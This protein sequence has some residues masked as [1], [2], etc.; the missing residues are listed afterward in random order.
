[1][2]FRSK[3]REL[4]HNV[5]LILIIVLF[6]GLSESLG[7]GSA[8]SA[9]LYKVT[10]KSN[11][12]VGY[13]ESAMG[14]TKLLTAL[15]VGDV[16]DRYGRAPVG[17][18]GSLAYTLATIMTAYCLVANAYSRNGSDDDGKGDSDSS[19]SNG[20]VSTT[21]FALWAIALCLWGF[22]RGV[23]D[24]PVLALFADSVP[25]GDRALFYFYLFVVFWAGALA[26]PVVAVLIFQMQHDEWTYR[27][28][29]VVLFVALA[30]KMVNAVLLCFLRDNA[31]LGAEAEHVTV[32]PSED[33]ME[34]PQQ[35]GDSV[36]GGGGYE[37]LCDEDGLNRSNDDI[38][39][40][41]DGSRD[42]K[43]WDDHTLDALLLDGQSDDGNS[44]RERESATK[45][46]TGNS[47]ETILH[48]RKWGKT[49][50]Q[51][52]RG[53][54]IPHIVFTASLVAQLGA[55]MTVKFFPLYFM[56]D[57][58]ATPATVQA[59]Y[60]GVP[61]AML[62]GGA[63]NGRL[64][65]P[66]GFGRVQTIVLFKGIGVLSLFILVWL[67]SQFQS[68]PLYALVPAFLAQT[69]FT[70]STYPLEESILMDFVPKNRR[71]RWKSLEAV[72]QFGWAGSAILGGYLIDRHD[73]AFT[74]I[75]TAVIQASAVLVWIVLLAVVPREERRAPGFKKSGN[76]EVASN[77]S[78]VDS[79][80]EDAT[81]DG[82]VRG[83]SMSDNVFTP[84][85]KA[86]GSDGE[87]DDEVSPFDTAVM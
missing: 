81:R 43:D 25:T 13:L 51:D 64:A 17:R 48:G 57:C 26:G 60:I 77:F 76:N 12:N 54:Y 29:S 14:L 73:Y 58:G 68:R 23:V 18:V 74:F 5:R 40:K 78:A 41:H 86:S 79:A 35:G 80:A 82:S 37:Y 84:I 49:R 39:E 6:A 45:S 59:I 24:G 8:L 34:N 61:L 11:M 85:K 31:A 62:A 15:P 44:A 32:A 22:G 19:N 65:G 69:G 33:F 36:P 56:V 2:H 16:S 20:G 7:F 46:M 53:K 28:L 42:A 10:G 63:I 47:N 83:V 55:G 66:L 87:S 3:W 52:M 9:Y 30:F 27:E 67:D 21:T 72:A 1:M 4:N 70:D 71:G 75:I 38:R 50:R